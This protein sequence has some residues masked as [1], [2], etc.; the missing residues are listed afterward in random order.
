MGLQPNGA[1]RSWV[2]HALGDLGVLQTCLIVGAC[3]MLRSVPINLVE[4]CS[5]WGWEAVDFTGFA[6][7]HHPRH[8]MLALKKQ[9]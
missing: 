4:T 6:S 2:E 5:E 9:S 3:V 7:H 8:G 1:P